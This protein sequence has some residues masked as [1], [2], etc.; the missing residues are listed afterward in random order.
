MRIKSLN[1]AKL[2]DLYDYEVLFN[3]DLT[4]IYGKN[5]CG[6]TTILNILSAIV[7]GRIYDLFAWSFD[8]IVLKYYDDSDPQSK[9]FS[10]RISHKAENICVEFKNREQTLNK[11]SFMRF[12]DDSD[13]PDEVFHF[14]SDK[15]SILASIKEEFNYIYLPLNRSIPCSEMSFNYR[16]RIRGSRHYF[17]YADYS[18]GKTI[19]DDEIAKTVDLVKRRH[20]EASAEVLA[21]NNN[22]R[23]KLLQSLLTANLHVSDTEF[24]KT[25]F[26]T[27]EIG[28]VEEIQTEYLKLLDSFGLLD[29]NTK[30]ESQSFFNWFKSTL[31]QVRTRFASEEKGK[32]TMPVSFAYACNGIE[33]MRSITSLAKEMEKTK[34]KAYDRIN[35]FLETINS[36]FSFDG[37]KMVSIDETGDIR[38]EIN[39]GNNYIPPAGLSS[40]EKQLFIFFANLVFNVEK[41]KSSIFIID[42]PELSLH[43]HWQK[44]FVEKAMSVNGNMQFILATH[45]PEIVCSYRDKMNKLVKKEAYNVST[46]EA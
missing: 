24:M 21:I 30:E 11:E 29:D 43:L 35:V 8:K 4:F 42:E 1:V 22:F 7:S 18:D 37:E 25:L 10:I 19:S 31:E 3:S 28:N 27:M 12:F 23:D 16:R 5:G 32:R 44:M 26:K 9:E 2:H 45:S 40:G 36:F 15:Y 46:Q 6:K 34:L 20:A 17:T 39:H 38:F 41:D 14:M 13:T 33:K